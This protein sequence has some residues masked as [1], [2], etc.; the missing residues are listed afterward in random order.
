METPYIDGDIIE[1]SFK[2]EWTLSKMQANL[3]KLR[4]LFEKQREANKK[5]LLLLDITDL[6]THTAD[7]RR[8][9]VIWMRENEFDKFAI[10]GGDTFLKYVS[11]L[12]IT[13]TGKVT[14]MRYFTSRDEALNWL[15]S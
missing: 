5:I 8:E 10:F 13:A 1:N 3:A 11:N 7:V 14:R 2:G 15:R 6:K 4:F 9:G 12:I